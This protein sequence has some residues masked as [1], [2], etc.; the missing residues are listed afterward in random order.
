MLEQACICERDPSEK[1][2]IVESAGG[3]IRAKA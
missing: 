3:Y 1:R 2:Y